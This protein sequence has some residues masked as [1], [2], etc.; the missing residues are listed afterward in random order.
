MPAPPAASGPDVLTGPRAL[1]VQLRFCLGVLARRLFRPRR[2]PLLRLG[3]PGF[4]RTLR[5][6]QDIR[7]TQVIR[8]GR[9]HHFSLLEPR[10]PSPAYDRMIANGG[11]SL[12]A[13]GTPAKRQIDLAVLAVTRACAYRCA[14][15]YES[16]NL[17]GPDVVPFARWRSLIGELQEIGVS[18]VV[19][20]GGEPLDRFEPVLEL[21]R[22][23]DHS[24][25]DFH[26]YT[27]GHGATP[28]R[29]QALVEAGLAAAGV[30]IDDH[31]AGRYDA[32]RGRAGAHAEALAALRLFAEA[33]VLA[34]ANVCLTPAL[35]R[36]GGLEQLRELLRRQGAGAMQLLEPRPCGALAGSAAADLL[37][38]AERREARRFFEASHAGVPGPVVYYPAHAE[39]PERLGC[40]MGGLSHLHVDSLGNVEPCV[41]LPVTFGNVVREPFDAVYARLR[42]A[43][44]RPLHARCPSLQ[45]GERVG[46]DR[47]R[48]PVLPVP[49]EAIRDE[50]QRLYAEAPRYHQT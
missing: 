21:L 5:L 33:G 36:E 17:G 50:W 28:E 23:A 12:A 27:S 46:F 25:S 26:L 40:L 6:M 24:R 15:C 8:V 42:A 4:L 41:F 35:V 29:V 3:G 43:V 1:P 34:Y 45:L 2:Y 7:S 44:P 30:G 47:A 9:H 16:A 49:H 32:L 19:L 10:W 13:A 14:H 39:A 38:E 37:G 18:V 48:Q 20:S 31:D 11:L 22:S